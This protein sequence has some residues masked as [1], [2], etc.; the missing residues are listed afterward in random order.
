MRLTCALC[1]RLTV[2]YA[3]IGS[4]PVGPRCASRAGIKPATTAKGS[5]IRFAKPVKRAPIPKTGD[6][7]EEIL[8]E[9]YDLPTKETPSRA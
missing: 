4:E 3:Y 9:K 5:R 7:F 6:L 1:G 2:P 8:E